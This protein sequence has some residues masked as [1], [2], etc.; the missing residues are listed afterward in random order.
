[1]KKLLSLALALVMCASLAACGGGNGTAAG[2]DTGSDVS[3][4]SG[5]PTDAQL[6]TLTE[7]YN[8]VAILY[9]DVATQA[10]ENGWTADEETNAK[11]QTIGAMLDPVGTA[12]TSDMS[13]LE[14]ADFDGLPAALLELKPE[15]EELAARVAEPFAGG[16]GSA[17]VTDEALKPL[18]NTYNELV[19]AFN[20]VYE[21]AEA[22]GWLNDEQTSAEL[23]AVYAMV[24][25]VGSG[26]T[27]DP[28]KLEDAD[29]DGLVAQLQ[30][31]LPAL[32]EIGQR[33]SVPYGDAG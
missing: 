20:E 6:Q 8:E 15:L 22:N 27:D 18:A 26:L 17:V 13:A 19:P 2:S 11:I 25:Y 33:V 4:G 3:S 1:M 30:E 31:L 29:L 28:A 21:A 14:G 9:N 7:A 12:L 5:G 10:Q 23:D 16:E 32:E 24:T